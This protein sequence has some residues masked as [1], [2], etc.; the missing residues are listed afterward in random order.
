MKNATFVLIFLCI[1]FKEEVIA[2]DNTSL[3]PQDYFSSP[4]NIPL[5]LAANFGEIRTNHFHMGLD[6]RTQSRENLPVFAAADGYISRISI[7]EY[8]FGRVIYITHPNGYITLY[9]HLNSFYPELENYTKARQY[10]NES[11][12]QDFTLHPNQCKVSKGQFIA[13]SGNTGASQGPHLHFEIRD[14]ETG[15]NLNPELFNFDI[16]DNIAPT[17][18]GVYW[19]DRRFSTYMA[20]AEKIPVT[21]KNKEYTNNITAEVASP[22]I[23]LGIRAE[24]KSNNSP[25]I[26]GI[27]KAELWVDDSLVNAFELNNLSYNETRYMNACVDYTRWVSNRQS[28]QHL[29]A[30]PGNHISIFSKT[31]ANGVIIFTDTL[32]HNIKIFV[33]DVSGNISTVKLHLRYN[34]AVEKNYVY[35]ANS[36][37][38]VPDRINELSS[39]NARVQF[40]KDVF[41]DAVPFTLTEQQGAEAMQVSPY[42][43]LHNNLVPVHDYY[44]IMI[45][46]GL[47][48]YNPL[49]Y[50]TVMQLISGKSEDIVKGEWLGNWMKGSFNALGKV[51][52]LID[53]VPPEIKTFIWNKDS[54]FSGE[55]NLI[56]KCSDNLKKVNSFRAEMDG[57]WLLFSKKGG[58]FMYKFDEH[59][60][61]GSHVL[62]I[63]VSDVA[64][65]KSTQSFCFTKL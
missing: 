8:G 33:S 50:R 54:T 40:S 58:Y 64:G 39:A 18:Y 21:F 49:R 12:Q 57:K 13:Y 62:N 59:C 16:P 45:K 23:S 53:T 61:P 51:R 1:L 9:A 26:F 27:Y 32:L 4:L 63:S 25:F 7:Q 52:L 29:S 48:D 55:K 43:N 42:I 46:S 28:I 24:D 41:Y 22:L 10:E 47:P 38:C 31:A 35:P 11:W 20:S 56:I 14:T 15:N 19:Y 44:E 30:L 60:L 2:Q 3:Y 5:Q 6:I 37:A 34:P 36:I 17:L 65:N